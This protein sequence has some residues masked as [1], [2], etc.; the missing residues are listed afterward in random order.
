V[1]LPKPSMRSACEAQVSPDTDAGSSG[2]P[3]FPKVFGG[4]VRLR[5]MVKDPECGMEVA[6]AHAAGTRVHD[7]TTLYFCSAGCVAKFDKEPHR[8][9]HPH[10]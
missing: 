10:P 3:V 5:I 7:H 1:A 9:G 8:Y 2:L 4:A 6:P